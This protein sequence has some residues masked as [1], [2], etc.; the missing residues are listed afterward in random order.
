MIR[1]P[2]RSTLFPYTTLFR[3]LVAPHHAAQPLHAGVLTRRLRL[4]REAPTPP[5]LTHLPLVS[6]EHLFVVR[7]QGHSGRTEPRHLRYGDG[8]VRR[9]C[10]RHGVRILAHPAMNPQLD[11]TVSGRRR[12]DLVEPRLRLATDVHERVVAE[13]LRARERVPSPSERSGDRTRI[14][15]GEHADAPLGWRR[16]GGSRT[17][18]LLLRGRPGGW[19]ERTGAHTVADVRGVAGERP[20]RGALIR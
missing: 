20:G 10:R 9:Q 6:H 16:R 3:S 18:S 8:F 15:C 11:A 14:D 12:V 17:Q 19:G 13:V 5:P 7:E 4:E 1:R 2:P